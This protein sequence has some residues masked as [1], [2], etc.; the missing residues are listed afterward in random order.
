MK[1]SV[2]PN[3]VTLNKPPFKL[4]AR[5]NA[6][7]MSEWMDSRTRAWAITA[8]RADSER[9]VQEHARSI[10]SEAGLTGRPKK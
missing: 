7:T 10:Y 5:G 8:V 3:Y 2:V 4:K 6:N 9:T 1:R